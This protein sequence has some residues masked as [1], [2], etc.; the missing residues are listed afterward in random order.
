M[1]DYKDLC[2]HLREAISFR[3]QA[4]NECR[5]EEEALDAIET[6]SCLIGTI[7]ASNQMAVAE[8]D[9]R[10]ETLKQAKEDLCVEIK[11]LKREI[12]ELQRGNE[13]LCEG[14]VLAGGSQ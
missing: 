12:D 9:R 3:G 5:L 8:K 6:L 2:Q 1:S 11:Q 7:Q 10:I 4:G 14:S 13:E